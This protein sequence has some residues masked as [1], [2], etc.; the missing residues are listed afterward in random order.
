MLGK[1]SKVVEVLM[2]THLESV[3]GTFSQPSGKEGRGKALPF[4]PPTP[5]Q[6]R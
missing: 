3:Q 4:T 6:A 1:L 2:Y 5:G